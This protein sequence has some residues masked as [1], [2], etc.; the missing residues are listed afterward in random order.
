MRFTVLHQAAVAPADLV[1]LLLQQRSWAEASDE[2]EL[3]VMPSADHIL[4]LL[5]EGKTKQ[6]AATLLGISLS[7]LYKILSRGG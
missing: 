1:K 2:F 3:L 5:D 7:G 6:E 4:A